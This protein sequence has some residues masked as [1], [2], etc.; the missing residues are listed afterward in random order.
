[1]TA[2]FISHKM[3]NY[4]MV[5]IRFYRSN[6]IYVT[7]YGKY[8]VILFKFLNDIV[9][10]KLLNA[11]KQNLYHKMVHLYF[12]KMEKILFPSHGEYVCMYKCNKIKYKLQNYAEY[13]LSISLP[14]QWF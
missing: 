3:E 1:M 4:L 5:Q 2:L 12:I 11:T 14:I 7:I 13:I 6:G 9:P 8:V 10:C